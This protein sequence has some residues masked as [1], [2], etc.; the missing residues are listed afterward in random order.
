MR[1]FWCG[2]FSPEKFQYFCFF[3]LHENV[4]CGYSL[5]AA[6]WA[7]FNEYPQYKF[8]W[9]NKNNIMRLPTRTAPPTLLSGAMGYPSYL[10][11]CHNHSSSW[12]PD[13]ASDKAF[14]FVKWKVLSIV[15]LSPQKRMLWYSLEVPHRGA[16]NEYPQHMLLWRNKKKK[17]WTPLLSIVLERKEISCLHFVLVS[18]LTST[19]K[20]VILH[21]PHYQ[22][23]HQ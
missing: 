7:T 19:L 18:F 12:S 9:R 20:I 2:F 5:E 3:F 10:E 15:L 17:N 13:R 14:F 4:C 23:R 11:L 1:V 21:C 8:L 6:R 22:I 16:S